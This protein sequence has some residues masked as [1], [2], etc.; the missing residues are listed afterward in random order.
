MLLIFAKRDRNVSWGVAPS[1][2]ER[3]PIAF[4]ISIP[5][6]CCES[7]GALC[8]GPFASCLPSAAEMR[9]VVVPGYGERRPSAFGAV[10]LLLSRCTQTRAEDESQRVG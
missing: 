10:R 1:Y 2:G 4:V 8:H 7:V 9:W 3:R 5:L 6:D